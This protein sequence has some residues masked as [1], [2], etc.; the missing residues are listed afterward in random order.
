LS[1][2]YEG[3]FIFPEA[4]DEAGLDQAIE[5]VKEEL[6]KL[7][8]SL[9]SSVRMGK[10]QFARAMKKEKSGYYVVLVFS[11][12]ADQ[13]DAFKARLKLSTNVFRHQF[14]AL[15]PASLTET[16]V[17]TAAETAAEA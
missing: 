15:D 7:G 10:K 4:L 6:E 5:R 9:D 2:V 12:A 17:E 11:L 8:G 1:K 16:A 14:S 3:L 13:V